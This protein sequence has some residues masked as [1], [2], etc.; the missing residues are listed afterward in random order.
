MQTRALAQSA[1]LQ[2]SVLAAACSVLVT[3]VLPP[4]CST[5]PQRSFQN[6]PTKE[7]HA[8]VLV[9]SVPQSST[10]LHSAHPKV[11]LLPLYHSAAL[12]VPSVPQCSTSSATVPQCH[13]TVSLIATVL[14]L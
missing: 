12:L 8:A 5:E 1:V 13:N 11:P 7:R 4:H 14:I 6:A 9:P 2:Y 10:V 3:A